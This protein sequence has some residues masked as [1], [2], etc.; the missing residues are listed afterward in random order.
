M[1]IEMSV[2]QTEE[3][4]FIER[5]ILS[6]EHEAGPAIYQQDFI[7]EGDHLG[8]C[9]RRKYFIRGVVR[10]PEGEAFWCPICARVWA[11][12]PVKSSETRI[13]NV[14]CEAHM[15]A[16]SWD[17]P[18]SILNHLPDTFWVPTKDILWP[19][20]VLLREFLLYCKRN[21]IGD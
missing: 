18:G 3:I 7:I 11:V 6:H 16:Y 2:S 5:E 4:D 8:S 9:L 10:I 21:N 1:V 20:A 12:C 13:N 19:T 15:P 17:T 14:K